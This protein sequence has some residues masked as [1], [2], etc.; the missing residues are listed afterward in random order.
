[1]TIDRL[2]DLF[3][4]K[5]QELMANRARSVV[6][7]LAAAAGSIAVIAGGYYVTYLLVTWLGASQ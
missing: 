1:M 6:V 5:F 7:M 2:M 3:V 4:E